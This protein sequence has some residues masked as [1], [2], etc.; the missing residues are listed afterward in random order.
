MDKG[1]I[2]E[3]A[4]Q[5]LDRP[6]SNSTL[7][8][9]RRALRTLGGQHWRDYA[10]A[11]GLADRSGYRFKA[12][13]QW[14]A[15]HRILSLLAE[16]D[17]ARKSGDREGKDWARERAEELAA[18]LEAEADYDRRNRRRPGS[19]AYR[20]TR[21]RKGK[22]K[23]LRG[24]KAGW[25]RRIA[26]PAERRDQEAILVMALAGVRSAELFHGVRM[27]VMDGGV[28]FTVRGAKTGQGYGQTWRRFTVKSPLAQRLRRSM[29]RTGRTVDTVRIEAVG[30][31]PVEAFRKRIKKAARRAGFP[32]ISAYSFRHAVGAD[33][34]AGGTPI[35][36]IAGVLGHSVDRTQQLYGHVR[37]GGGTMQVEEVATAQPVRRSA[38]EPWPERPTS[39]P[40]PNG[41][42]PG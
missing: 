10:E 26:N 30:K 6:R 16:S 27:E 15:A 25:Q 31:D 22:R 12:A 20:G 7:D 35:E 8:Q 21:P 14:G 24:L 39:D 32:R 2:R 17:R 36:Q 23:S 33:L 1:M 9:Y 3:T 37:Q 42:G 18:Q 38:P 11:R 5:V 40:E 13:W 4:R 28:R 41:P 34:K 19:R 29:E